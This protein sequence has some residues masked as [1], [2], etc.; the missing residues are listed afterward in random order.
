MLAICFPFVSSLNA[1]LSWLPAGGSFVCSVQTWE[2]CQSSPLT[3]DK[4]T[5]KHIDHNIKIFLSKWKTLRSYFVH[6][7]MSIS[8]TSFLLA[9]LFSVTF[10]LTSCTPEWAQQWSHSQRDLLH[11]G[12]AEGSS[13]CAWSH[14]SLRV[15]REEGTPLQEMWKGLHL[16][17]NRIR[18]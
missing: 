11:A 15:L 2:W 7:S 9:L 16:C 8:K 3:L 18:Y 17:V 6:Y 12:V 1:K 10:L 13:V 5:N 14:F 4:K